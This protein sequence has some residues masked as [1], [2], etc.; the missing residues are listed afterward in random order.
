[1]RK[2]WRILLSPLLSRKILKMRFSASRNP[3]SSL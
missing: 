2:F 3:L 1:M